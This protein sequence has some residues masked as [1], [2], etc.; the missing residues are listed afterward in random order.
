MNKKII[1]IVIGI[2]LVIAIG[3]IVFV[4]S[5]MEKMI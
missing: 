1:I 4:N 5:N 2:I 3:S